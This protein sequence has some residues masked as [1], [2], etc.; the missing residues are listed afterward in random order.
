M[1]LLISLLIIAGTAAAAYAIIRTN[2]AQRAPQREWKAAPY[3]PQPPATPPALH[4]QD[5]GR[6]M[7]EVVNESKFQPLLKELAGVHGD[8]PANARYVATLVPDD[9]NPYEDK[10]VTVF[11]EGRF[12]GQLGTKDAVVFRQRLALKEVEGQPTTC[13]AIVK[14]GGLFEGR[15]MSYVVVLDVEPL[16]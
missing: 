2:P 4:W 9:A 3:A 8:A 1:E 15:R 7:V 6:F 10:A 13:D 14:G 11:V 16:A 12:V 5:E